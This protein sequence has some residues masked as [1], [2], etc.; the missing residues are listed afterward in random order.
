VERLALVLGAEIVSTFDH[1]E[2]VRLGQCRLVEE[3]LLG[4]DKAIRFS[5]V[6]LGEAC[7]IVLRGATQQLLDEAERSLHDALCV[8]QQTVRDQR[9]VPGGGA[10]EMLMAKAVEDAARSTPGKRSLAVEA[11]ARALRQLPTILADNAGL[12]SAEL[13]TALRAAHHRGETTAGLDL[14]E[15]RVA[16]MHALGVTEPLRVKLAVLN[17]ASEAAEML[18]RVDEILK[19]PPRKREPDPGH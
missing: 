6:P 9:V 11:F 17:S 10:A 8:L 15:G 14:R 3:I 16:D 4:E 13:V 19:A 12:D 7:T 18:L 1:P 2:R 5:G